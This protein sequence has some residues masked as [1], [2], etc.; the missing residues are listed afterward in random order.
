MPSGEH[1]A[2]AVAG[3]EGVHGGVQARLLG[4][5]GV[6]EEIGLVRRAGLFEAEEHD[7]RLAVA[8]PLDV[9]GVHLLADGAEHLVR[10]VRG[11]GEND[12][13]PQKIASSARGEDL[14]V[15][16]APRREKPVSAKFGGSL[17]GVGGEGLR[18][19]LRRRGRFAERA[20][21]GDR[22]GVCIV[23]PLLVAGNAAKLHRRP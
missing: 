7:S 11:R 20:R 1:L 15:D 19:R 23:V 9:E 16:V 22:I 6:V 17:R 3:V 18:K 21:T 4:W 5:R 8:R 12:R 2:L 14:R 10:R 13:T